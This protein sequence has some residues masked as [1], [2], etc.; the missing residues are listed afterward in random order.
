MHIVIFIK[1]FYFFIQ[2]VYFDLY[3]V[4]ILTKIKINFWKVLL[5]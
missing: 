4:W 5:S 1:F 2:Y 3:V